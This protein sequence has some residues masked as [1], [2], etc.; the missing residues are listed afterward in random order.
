MKENERFVRIQKEGN[1]FGNLREVWVDKQT[2][3]TYL[4][5][6]SGYAGGLTVMLDAAGNPIITRIPRED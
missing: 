4:W 6:N 5:M 1:S 3:V 2:G